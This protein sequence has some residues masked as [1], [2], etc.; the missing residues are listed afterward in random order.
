MMS[1]NR[2]VVESIQQK[3]HGMI[4]DEFGEDNQPWSV[5]DQRFN[6]QRIVEQMNDQFKE[7]VN[8]DTSAVATL[9]FYYEMQTVFN[10]YMQQKSKQNEDAS[11]SKCSLL[12][13]EIIGSV[14][15]VK[16]MSADDLRN[17][18]AMANFADLFKVMLNEYLDNSK[19]PSQCRSR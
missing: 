14:P 10:E 1:E 9:E 11:Q 4:E 13:D 6:E 19:G 5:E 16:N 17:S 18:Q 7:G 2:K 15:S 8:K 3:I 12:S